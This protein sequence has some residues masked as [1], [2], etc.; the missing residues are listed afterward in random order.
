MQLQE[1]HYSSHV[2]RISLAPPSKTGA[3]F[4]RRVGIRETQDC[5][6]MF[7]MGTKPH[8][9]NVAQR[10]IMLHTSA[11]PREPLAK[12]ISGQRWGQ[13][14]LLFAGSALSVSSIL[15]PKH[16]RKRPTTH[17]QFPTP[18]YLSK[19]RLLLHCMS[20]ILHS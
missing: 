19:P 11:S 6:K 3:S 1:L 4:Y 9:L 7:R 8:S 13:F 18:S 5:H 14:L 2:S 16:C 15:V 10:G 20:V 17:S 12:S